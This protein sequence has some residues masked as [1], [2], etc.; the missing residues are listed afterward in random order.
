MRHTMFSVL[1]DEYP[2]EDIW[3]DD[4]YRYR[5]AQALAKN[6]LTVRN[7]SCAAMVVCA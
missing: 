3:G 1:N 4:F 5:D 6:S 7:R 2:G